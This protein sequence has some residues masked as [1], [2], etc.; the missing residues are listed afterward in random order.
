MAK[1][2]KA[3]AAGGECF[4]CDAPVC[5]GAFQ[6]DHFPTPNSAGGT[7]V[8]I[9]CL[10]CHDLKDRNS[11]EN[12]PLQMVSRSLPGIAAASTLLQCVQT[13]NA[14][15]LTLQTS[16]LPSGW[17][18]WSRESRVFYAKAVRVAFAAICRKP[19]RSTKRGCEV[20]ACA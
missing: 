17:D 16:R 14:F 9:A 7:D 18:D 8:V 5:R 15:D 1:R 11:L 12:W 2:A 13:K 10:G 6:M 3:P 20:S 4:Y 19:A